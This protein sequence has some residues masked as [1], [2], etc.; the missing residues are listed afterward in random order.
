MQISRLL[1]PNRRSLIRTIIRFQHGIDFNTE[2]PWREIDDSELGENAFHVTSIVVCRACRSGKAT[3][4]D[5]ISLVS[6][7]KIYGESGKTMSKQTSG[8]E[9]M[10]RAVD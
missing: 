8:R 9:S 1:L 3:A 6:A 10:I 7:W 2:Y 5:R 4:R